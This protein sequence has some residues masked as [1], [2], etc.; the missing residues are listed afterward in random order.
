MQREN[1]RVFISITA[2]DI[3]RVQ[4]LLRRLEAARWQVACQG[5]HAQALSLPACGVGDADVVVAFIGRDYLQ[6]RDAF[7]TELS[8]AACALRKPY[9][10]VAL[11][12]LPEL[13]A[14]AEMLAARDGF[15]VPDEIGP[16]LE[17]WADRPPRE[18]PPLRTQQRHALKPFE[19]CDEQYAFVS[20]AHDDAPDIYPII[21]DLYEAGWNLWYD[22]GIRITERYLPEIAQHVRDCEVFLLF[23]TE[24]SINRPFVI[25]FEL[26]YARRLGKTIVP[27]MVDLVGQMPDGTAKLTR[28]APGEALEQTLKNVG[29]RNYG[30]RTAVP[31]KDKKDEE[32]DLAQLTPMKDYTYRLSGDGLWLE[33]YTG[34]AREVAVPEEHCGL[35]VRGLP[36][37][38]LR[39]RNISRVEVPRSVNYIGAK[40]FRGCG[41]TVVFPRP[42][43]DYAIEWDSSGLFNGCVAIPLTCLIGTIATVLLFGDSID[44]MGGWQRLLAAI[45]ITVLIAAVAFIITIAMTI[46]GN[47]KTGKENWRFPQASGSEDDT[48]YPVALAC[49]AEDTRTQG[50]IDRL[51]AEG[52][53]MSH[54]TGQGEPVPEH[55]LLIAFL[56]PGFFNNPDLAQKVA[57]AVVDGTKVLPIY[58]DM[59]PNELPDEFAASI[60]QFQGIHY[61]SPESRYLV[62]R[63]LKSNGCWRDSTQDFEYSMTRKGVKIEKYTG[64]G[65]VVCIPARVFDQDHAVTSIGYGLFSKYHG[66]TELFIPETVRKIDVDNSLISWHL[67]TYIHVDEGNGHFSSAGGALCE[68]GKGRLLLCPVKL[69]AKKLALPTYIKAISGSAFAECENIEEIVMQDGVEEIGKGAFWNC[70]SLRSVLIPASVKKVGKDAFLCLKPDFLALSYSRSKAKYQKS[71]F[72]N[73]PELT[74]H[75][76]AGSS[77]ERYA[78]A[79][80]IPVVNV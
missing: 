6:D 32:Y 42:K 5:R 35:P 55:E 33:K 63:T 78:K 60:G 8:Y 46:H 48:G 17:R 28:T 68:T 37:T 44:S 70:H 80:G 57:G 1:I 72:L 74:I 66:C 75:T 21:K 45:G 10:L 23:V 62:R 40:A 31:P 24:C 11:E 76:P 53:L 26:A 41:A 79:Q 59:Q 34:S 52:F 38:F 19:A 61:T 51:R 29:I 9:I 65:D 22:E 2:S 25:D 36:T 12:D 67:L 13:P 69:P 58:Y 49:Y 4:P 64:K 56:S 43:E 7:V 39:Q 50:T 54:Y 30:E 15:V 73:C 71:A 27:V 47:R 16:A 20:Y 77:A 14:D 3:Q 18:L